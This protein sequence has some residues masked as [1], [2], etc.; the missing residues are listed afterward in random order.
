MLCAVYRV[1]I[2]A[3]TSDLVTTVFTV[4]QPAPIIA[5]VLSHHLLFQIPKSWCRVGIT[6]LY[7]VGTS[8]YFIL[9][10]VLG[11]NSFG[12]SGNCGVTLYILPWFLFT[13]FSKA[14]VVFTLFV[15]SIDLTVLNMEHVLLV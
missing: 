9:T 15:V 11:L 5:H 6:S 7:G 1:C 10:F 13:V 12:R 14:A 3:I 2:P 4:L 8:F